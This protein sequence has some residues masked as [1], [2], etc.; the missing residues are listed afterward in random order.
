M[1]T[2]TIDEEVQAR[3]QAVAAP[4]EDFAAFLAAAAQEM[5]SPAANSRPK[6]APKC[7][8]CL[9]AR[10]KM[11]LMQNRWPK[12]AVSITCRISHLFLTRSVKQKCDAILDALPPEK[13]AEAE[14]Q[15]VI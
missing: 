12:C 10:A 6:A 14:R 4:E 2:V 1:L 15:G 7:R 3:F 13:I 9:M 11:L 8:P 5:P